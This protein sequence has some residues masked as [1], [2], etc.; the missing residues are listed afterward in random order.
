MIEQTTVRLFKMLVFFSLHVH[1]LLFLLFLQIKFFCKMNIVHWILRTHVQPAFSGYHKEFGCSVNF[2]LWLRMPKLFVIV[3]PTGLCQCLLHEMKNA[4]TVLHFSLFQQ[5]YTNNKFIGSQ[6]CTPILFSP[7]MLSS[8][9]R[10]SLHR[11]RIRFITFRH[12]FI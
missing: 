12:S 7:Q 8:I 1:I 9:C 5:F 10:G 4:V 2:A 11:F 6:R 3:L